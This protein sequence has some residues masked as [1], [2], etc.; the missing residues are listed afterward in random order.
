MRISNKN[1]SYVLPK[2]LFCGANFGANFICGAN[3][4]ANFKTPDHMLK[5]T[6][7]Y[8]LDTRRQLANGEYPIK[9]TVYYGGP[10]KRYKTPF[11]SKPE[12]FARLYQKNIRNEV[13]KLFKSIISSWL[14]EQTKLA[15]S[16]APFS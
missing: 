6:L 13:F 15:E 1:I 12:D 10:K 8:F 2:L 3:F 11:K 7:S 16:I 9:L 5:P 14:A 4:G